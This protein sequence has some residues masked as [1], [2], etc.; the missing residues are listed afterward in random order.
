MKAVEVQIEQY[1]PKGN[2]EIH[3]KFFF[4]KLKRKR[5]ETLGKFPFY[6]RLT[7]LTVLFG[8]VLQQLT[9]IIIAINNTAIINP[10]NEILNS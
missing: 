3:F 6:Y 8:I 2:K 4:Q 10:I 7:G 9:K 1:S 5:K